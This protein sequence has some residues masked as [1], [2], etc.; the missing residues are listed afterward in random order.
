[1]LVERH[2]VIPINIPLDISLEHQATR[3]EK[4]QHNITTVQ[5]QVVAHLQPT[6]FLQPLNL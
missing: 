4:Q 1:M 2:R 3:A 5:A 6:I